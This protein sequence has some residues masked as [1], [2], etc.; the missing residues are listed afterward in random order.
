MTPLLTWLGALQDDGS[1]TASG[2]PELNIIF[3]TDYT[4]TKKTANDAN[5]VCFSSPYPPSL[6]VFLIMLQ[7]RRDLLKEEE[8]TAIH[9]STASGPL[10]VS[11][12]VMGAD[13]AWD[14]VMRR[15]FDG[16]R[17]VR[18]YVEAGPEHCYRTLITKWVD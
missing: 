4:P 18:V 10:L 9:V 6:R 1:L 8:M 7:M 16:V 15:L 14:V 13:T 2:I 17:F 3:G 11:Q 12:D 5:L